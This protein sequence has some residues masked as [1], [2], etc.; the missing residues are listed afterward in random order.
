MSCPKTQHLL[1]EYFANDLGPVAKEE[2]E[3]HL[4]DCEFCNLELESLLLTNGK[5]QQW[6]DQSVP[7]WD[8]GLELFRQEHRAARPGPGFWGRWQWLPTA[9]SFAMLGVMLLNVSIV[10]GEQGLSISFGGAQAIGS[11]LSDFRQSQRVELQS[12]ISRFE[13]RQDSNNLQLMQ[14]VMEQ[15]QQNAAENLDRIYAYF[16][17]QR[18]LDLQD[19]R[20]GYEQLVNSD[21][22]TIRSLRQLV[23]YVGFQGVVR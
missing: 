7:H 2:L 13:D 4:A 5:L 15:T 22:E 8:R 9:A 18:L 17:Q 20:A 23:N 1:S 12:L 19:M 3:K 10:T 11:Q 21:S 14:A 6:Q 16:E